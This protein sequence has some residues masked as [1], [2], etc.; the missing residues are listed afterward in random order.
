MTQAQLFQPQFPPDLTGQKLAVASL[1]LD[2]R[3]KG[4]LS[5]KEI[6]A[7]VGLKHSADVR[8]IC[9]E[10]VD[11]YKLQIIGDRTKATG[12]YRFAESEE[13]FIDAQMPNLAQAVTTFQRVRS[14]LGEKRFK[15]ALIRLGIRDMM[16]LDRDVKL[17][18]GLDAGAR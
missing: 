13:E 11:T 4:L 12:G 18:G 6:A 16:D 10:L 17:A 1:L 7:R 14:R 3:G 5:S 9:S 15:T 8:N 2:H